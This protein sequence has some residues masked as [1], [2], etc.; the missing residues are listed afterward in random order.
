MVRAQPQAQKGSHWV[1]NTGS[2]PQCG[3][4]A[5]APPPSTRPRGPRVPRPGELG[6]QAYLM[7]EVA[8]TCP[9]EPTQRT[10]MEA[11]TTMRSRAKGLCVGSRTPARGREPDSQEDRAAGTGGRALCLWHARARRAHFPACSPAAGPA[12][13]RL[14]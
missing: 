3:A 10:T 2:P 11:R 8:N 1:S 6:A 9:L 14:C 5:C 13:T 4:Q 7:A 12:D